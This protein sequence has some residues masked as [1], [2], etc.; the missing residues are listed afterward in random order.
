MILLLGVAVGMLLLWLKN[1]AAGEGLI[2][3]TGVAVTAAGMVSLTM[4]VPAI[5]LGSY[6]PPEVT[7]TSAE[8]RVL[9]DNR[10][11][12]GSASGVFFAFAANVGTKLQYSFYEET[13]EGAFRLRSIP[14]DKTEVHETSRESG[15]KLIT[16]ESHEPAIDLSGGVCSYVPCLGSGF[17][18]KTYIL[19][20]PAGSIQYGVTLDGE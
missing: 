5:I 7:E 19:E 17:T 12:E 15:A 6:Q 2:S 18:E 8:L 13:P 9:N 1:L 10:Q 11:V 20:V 14:A 3:S 16:I 4:M